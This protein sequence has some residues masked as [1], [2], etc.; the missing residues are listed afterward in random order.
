MARPLRIE[1]QGALYHVTSRGDH[2]ED[3]YRDDNDRLAWLHVL[4]LSC[5]RFNISVQAY[6]LMPNHYHLLLE[7]VDGHLS[8][9]MRQ[10]NGMYSQY[11]NRRHDRVGHVFQGRYKAILIQKNTHLLEVIRYIVLNPL[12][13][14]QINDLSEWPWSSHHA[15]SGIQSSPAWLDSGWVLDQFA[16]DRAE[17][18][19]AYSRFVS[20]G[21]G[22]ASPLKKTRHQLILG[23]DQFV[24]EHRTSPIRPLQNVS[25]TQRRAL[26]L[27]LAEYRSRY[28]DRS[29]AMVRAYYSTAFTMQQIG[30]HFGVSPRTVS[31]NIKRFERM[32]DCIHY[33]NRT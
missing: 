23:D 15:V 30:D 8:K 11:F 17:A 25:R 26:V 5:S 16:A 2:R 27:S 29:E 10:L 22:K 20:E 6:C 13:A 28:P 3:I 32:V 14:N 4:A 1:Y 31:R 9:A 21:V 18:K 24:A 7:T 33:R 19:L 12:R